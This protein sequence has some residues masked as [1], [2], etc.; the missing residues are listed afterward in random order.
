MKIG[1]LEFKDYAAAKPVAVTPSGTFLT[2]SDIAGMPVLSLGSTYALDDN[3]QWKL[4][5]ERIALEP[6][7]RLGIIGVGLLT[8]DEV[9]EHIDQRTPFGEEAKRAEM[10]YVNELVK[11]LARGGPLPEW[12][13][14]PER[15]FPP[16]PKWRRRRRCIYLRLTNR[17]LFCENTTDSVTTPFADY[18]RDHVHPAFVAQGFNVIA[19]EGSDDVRA[20]FVTHT[21]SL[22]TVYISGIGH[23]AYHLYTGNWGDHIL[24]INHYDAQEVESKSIHFLSCQTGRDLGPDAVSNGAHSYAGYTEN[25]T[26][27]WDDGTTPAVDEFELFARADSTYDIEMA[28]G[29]TAQQAYDATIQAFDAAIAEVPNTVAAT[30]LAWDREHLALHGDV[31]TTIKPYRAIKICFPIPFLMEDALV[32][33]GELGDMP[34]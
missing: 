17:V 10:G 15:P 28:N 16:I 18:R 1:D 22:L 19:L 24:E 21:K 32:S 5:R 26:L 33:A 4:T 30:W 9:M 23:G 29:A 6:D 8:K 20:N 2:A 31:S 14:I 34:G 27:I 12:P 7:F 13:P 25:F 3:T 11:Q